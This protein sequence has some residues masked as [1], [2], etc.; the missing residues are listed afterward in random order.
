MS[1]LAVGRTTTEARENDRQ[2][3]RWR[4][5][6]KETACELWWQYVVD[7]EVKFWG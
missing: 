4:Q 1:F 3:W 2:G 5:K 7:I 6:V